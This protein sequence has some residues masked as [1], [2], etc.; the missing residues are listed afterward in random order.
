VSEDCCYLTTTG[1]LSGEPREVEL[2]FERERETIYMLSGN[3]VLSAWVRNI[4]AQP[5]VSV[6]IGAETFEGRASV[7]GDEEEI[8][9]VRELVAAKYDRLESA[10]RREGVPVAVEL[11]AP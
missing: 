4:L 11:Q 1:R 6:R 2:W 5:S 7:V 3:G 9:R 8:A 10:W